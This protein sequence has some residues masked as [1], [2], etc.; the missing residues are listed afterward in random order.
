MP[1][2]PTAVAERPLLNPDLTGG[3]F[4]FAS[5]EHAVSGD[6]AERL[7]AEP[8]LLTSSFIG[9]AGFEPTTPVRSPSR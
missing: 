9:T 3:D 4:E 5:I 8:L 1:S 7:K 6:V 2:V